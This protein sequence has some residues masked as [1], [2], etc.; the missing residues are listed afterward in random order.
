MLCIFTGQSVE[1]QNTGW[2]DVI[3]VPEAVPEVSEQPQSATTVSAEVLEREK[4]CIVVQ[5]SEEKRGSKRKKITH[6]LVV[7]QQYNTLLLKQENLK[8][9]KRKLELEV[10]LLEERIKRESVVGQTLTTINLSPIL[11]NHHFE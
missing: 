4:T 2:G 1:E 11:T 10:F 3:V 5:E 8:L 6:D 7:E 9:K